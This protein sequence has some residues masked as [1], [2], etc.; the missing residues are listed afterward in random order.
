M[1]ELR[2][3]GGRRSHDTLRRV[4]ARRQPVRVLDCPAG[5]G[6][7]A[8]HLRELGWEVH[9]GDIDPGNFKAE[10]F[11]FTQVNLNRSLPLPDASFDA[12][13]CANG[14]HRLF[15]PGAA[16]QEFF[17]VLKPGGS[18]YIT[19]NNYASINKRLRFLLYGSI[20]N[21]INEGT[22]TQTSDDPEAHVR[23]HLF[24]PQLAHLLG[25]AG[26]QVVDRQ[27]ASVKPIHRL[28]APLAWLI[29]LATLCIAPRS[30][31]R[32]HVAATRGAA[33]CP[34]GKYLYL[35]AV[36]PAR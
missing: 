19:I 36:K 28:L 25:E 16:I 26:F 2:I 18:L 10:G 9:C 6:A 12:V 33:I 11:P 3:I 20:T 4:L 23:M 7:L 27:S 29:A 30:R 1:N 35:E 21:T 22:F 24:Y 17:R 32:N 8:H 14:L 31:A 15:C 13:I 34:G 5:T